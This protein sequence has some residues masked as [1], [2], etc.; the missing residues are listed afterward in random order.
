MYPRLDDL[1][2][3]ILLSL[4]SECWGYMQVL[5]PGLSRAG[6]QTQGF[7]HTEQALHL[8]IFIPR[9]LSTILLTFNIQLIRKCTHIGGRV[10]GMAFQSLMIRSA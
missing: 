9:L 10:W 1:G 5:P 7:V 2:L 3:V 4:P 8:L 6:N